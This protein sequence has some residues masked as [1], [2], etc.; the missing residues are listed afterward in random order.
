MVPKR[1]SFELEIM[2]WLAIGIGALLGGAFA[3]V[4][5]L[6]VIGGFVLGAFLLAGIVA[7]AC[8]FLAKRQKWQSPIASDPEN[9]TVLPTQQDPKL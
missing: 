2:A 1:N 9:S 7:T 4:V 8:L 5:W 6:R 3:G